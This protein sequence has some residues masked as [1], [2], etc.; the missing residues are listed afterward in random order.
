MIDPDPRRTPAEQDRDCWLDDGRAIWARVREADARRSEAAWALGDWVHRRD[1]RYGDLVA[2]ATEIG[3]DY[4][5]L[6]GCASVAQAFPAARR[7]PTLSF[8][9]HQAARVLPEADRDRLLVQAELQGWSRAR[10]RHEVTG[11]KPEADTHRRLTRLEREN[12]ALRQAAAAPT[13]PAQ[14]SDT[15]AEAHRRNQ[16]DAREALR[17]IESIA[18][19]LESPDVARAL[20]LV[21]GNAA[22]GFEKKTMKMLD[23]FRA[24]VVGIAPRIDAALTPAGGPDCDAARHDPAADTSIGG[25]HCDAARHNPAAD[26]SIG[27]AHCDA[28]RH[29]PAAD[30]SIG[31]AHCDATRHDPA[32]DTATGGAHCDATHHDPAAEPPE[33]PPPRRAGG[34]P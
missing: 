28:T 23:E 15:L 13:T 3:V 2:A 31:G 18:A 34:V 12:E 32:A 6:R 22:L 11:A 29:D 19:R 7:H 25:A 8:G 20:G 14:S 33:S 4:D 17:L 30:T 10:M 24:G 27:G 21:H 5:Y 9:H 1:R 26:T 16:R